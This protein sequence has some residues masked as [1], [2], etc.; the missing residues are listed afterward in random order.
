MASASAS[1]SASASASSAGSSAQQSALP[2]SF[3]QLALALES[4]RLSTSGGAR[5]ALLR[6]NPYVEVIVDGK[7]P[8][9]TETAKAT[10]SPRWEETMTLLVTPYSKLLLRVYDHSSFKRDA[11]LGEAAVDV[12]GLLRKHGGALDGVS[13]QVDLR[14]PAGKHHHHHHHQGGADAASAGAR[15]HQSGGVLNVSLGGMRVDAAALNMAQA[16]VSVVPSA[17]PQPTNGQVSLQK[18]ILSLSCSLTSHTFQTLQ[19]ASEWVFSRA[20]LS[21]SPFSVRKATDQFPLPLQ[22]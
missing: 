5:A 1:G 3:S 4:A 17:S 10:Y 11:L 7:P 18:K 22:S 9:R 13:M 16:G 6:P 19:T 8:R 21:L 12:F 14:A 20:C 15:D 2:P